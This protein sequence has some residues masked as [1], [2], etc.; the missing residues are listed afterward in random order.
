MAD[1]A[2]PLLFDA[3]KRAERLAGLLRMAVAAGLGL[4][5]VL[6]VRPQAAN[7]DTVLWT[8]WAYAA[9][10]MTGYFL[11]GFFGWLLARSR[12]YRAW[13]V[14]P[15][16]AGDCLF[17]LSGLWM[18][19]GNVG[20]GSAVTLA[21]PSAWL[22]P[23]V[24][25]FGALRVDPRVLWVMTL[26]LVA[27]LAGLIALRHGEWPVQPG[28]LERIAPFFAPPPNMMRLAMIAVAGAVLAVAAA[29]TRALLVRS[30]DEAN[31]RA[32]LTRYLPAQ[33]ADDLGE[34]GLAAMQEGTRQNAGLLFIDI[35]GFTGMT[36]EMPPQAVSQFVSE[37]R[38]RVSAVARETGGIIDKFMG[39]AVLIV[40]SGQ[41]AAARCLTCGLALRDEISDWSQDRGSGGQP[42]VRV[43]IGLH[44]GEVFSGVVGDN[45]RLEYSVFGDAVNIAARLES[46]TRDLGLDLIASRDVI[47]AAGATPQD[48]GMETLAP[49]AVRGR[50]GALSLAGLRPDAKAE[51]AGTAASAVESRS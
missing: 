44:W 29:R 11:L 46:L 27:G 1:S 32:N 6:V 8:Q 50:E 16:A 35:R 28:S 31:R 3:E 33:L 15:V 38:R 12:Y 24:L 20:A 10:G 26:S 48:F 9:I 42:P 2:G 43:G 25:A 36:Q 18:S 17:V 22:V 40:F 5:F 4:T 41:D 51:T 23:L 34:A 14:W 45:D 19:V 39:D 13:M 47:A 30:I 7:A 37:Y 49:L 21:F